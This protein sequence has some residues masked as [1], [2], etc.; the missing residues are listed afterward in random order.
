MNHSILAGLAAGALWGLTFIAPNFIGAASAGE[1]VIVRYG[2]Y[3]F[4]SVFYLW[5][6]GFNPFRALRRGDWIR[7]IA[8]GALGNSL[9]YLLMAMSVRAG[10]AALTA[11]IIGTLPVLFAVVGNL[12]R[13]VIGWPGLML[14]LGP[15]GAGIALLAAGD[16]E[17]ATLVFS[18]LGAGLALAAVASWL[19]YGLT[20]ARYM[21]SNTARSPLLWAALVGVGTMVTLPVLAAGAM[22][23]EG[24]LFG[25]GVDAYGP[26]LFWGLVLGTVS[27]WLATWLWNIASAGVPPV[28]LGYL[29]VSETVFALIY[30]FVLDGRLPGLLELS[31]AALL[32]GG[33][34]VGINLTRRARDPAAAP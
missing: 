33:V 23:R 22:L 6:I 27:S 8:F 11:L 14:A 1:L 29:I 16:T 25:L 12:Q 24:V 17:G 26:L 10:G 19:I 28:V 31:S 13:P 34:L 4:C 5:W 21:A 15:I 2:A 30:A 7:L 9:Y 20:N 3:G 18:P 32:V